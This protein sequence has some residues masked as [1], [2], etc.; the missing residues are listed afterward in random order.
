VTPPPDPGKTNVASFRSKLLIAMMLVVAAI[1]AIAVYFAERNAAANVETALQREFQS[2]LAVLHSRQEIRHAALVERCR[3]LI[4]RPR[5]HAALEDNALDLLYPTAKDELRDLMG[6]TSGPVADPVAPALR[7]QFYRFLDRQGALIAP[8]NNRD[9]GPLTPT[10]ESSL[11]LPSPPERPQTGYLARKAAGAGTDEATITEIIAMPIFSHENGELIAALVLGFEPFEF[12][13]GRPTRGLKSGIWLDGRLHLP[14]ITPSARTQIAAKVTQAIASQSTS[15]APN[16]LV[17]SVDGAP[18]LLFYKTLNPGSLFPPAY[19]VSLYPLAPLHARQRQLRWQVVGTG[20][21]LLVAGLVASQFLALRLSG[22]V[23]KLARDSDE[24]FVQRQRAEAAL[25]H[26]SEE[27]QRSAR[28]SADASHQ[29][30][31]PVAVLRAGLEELLSRPNLTPAECNEVAALIHQTYRLA[32]VIEDL[33]L[34]SRIDA[35]RVQIDFSNVNL[36]RLIEG[37]LDDLSA[38][39]DPLNL[40]VS[41][42]IPPAVTIAGEQRYLTLILQN[43]LE[44]ARKYNRP[45]GRIRIAVNELDGWAILIIGNTGRPIPPEMHTHIFERFH[46]GSMG[47]NVPGHGLGLNLAREL[48]RIHGGDLVLTRSDEDWTEFEARFRLSVRGRPI[49]A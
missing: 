37:W 21:L 46:R 33:L 44:N 22:P 49:P 20:I 41:T 40:R 48:A 4:R 24:N 25:E 9:V 36:T 6:N 19:E 18:H 34:L 3:A 7:A 32:S 29:L 11:S 23:E 14:A 10:E 45:D 43:L 8:T 35:G 31:T 27:L 13:S 16:R 26:T 5:I 38:L 1:T 15:P 17:V 2:D 39:P 28:F 47:E 42:Q 30:K 12:A